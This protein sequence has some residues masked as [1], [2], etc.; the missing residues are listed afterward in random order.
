M[1]KAKIV[2]VPSR[3]FCWSTKSSEYETRKRC[4]E[5]LRNQ[6]QIRRRKLIPNAY[7][8][9]C[10]QLVQLV[11]CVCFVVCCFFSNCCCCSIYGFFVS[12]SQK[13]HMQTSNSTFYLFQKAIVL[14]SLERSSNCSRH[15]WNNVCDSLF[16][17]MNL[18]LTAENVVSS[19]CHECL[20]LH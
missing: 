2:V 15:I 9:A 16:R 12:I 10:S 17:Q 1:K 13:R 19:H 8:A 11:F 7:H 20:H 3:R 14:L 18:I 5:K 4:K 6:T